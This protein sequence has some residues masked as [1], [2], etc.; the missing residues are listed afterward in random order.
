[1]GLGLVEGFIGVLIVLVTGLFF[2]GNYHKSKAK[3]A[4]DRAED[5]R[6]AQYA[7]EEQLR[8]ERS[9]NNIKEKAHDEADEIRETVGNGSDRVDL[10]VG[11]YEHGDKMR[12]D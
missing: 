8:T 10:G 4:N 3:K 12:H 9:V 7:A 5:H 2:R 1:M 11:V 6:K